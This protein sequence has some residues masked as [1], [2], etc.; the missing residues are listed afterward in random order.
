MTAFSTLRWGWVFLKRTR[1]LCGIQ[2]TKHLIEFVLVETKWFV[3]S[4]VNVIPMRQTCGQRSSMSAWSKRQALVFYFRLRICY[5]LL[6]SKRREESDLGLC[7]PSVLAKRMPPRVGKFLQ[8]LQP[9]L[10][11]IRKSA[12]RSGILFAGT[13]VCTDLH[14]TLLYILMSGTYSKFV[15]KIQ[16]PVLGVCFPQT[17]SSAGRMFAASRYVCITT[18][19]SF[20]FHNNE[21]DE[22]P[23]KLK[24]TVNLRSFEKYPTPPETC[25]K[26][27]RWC[28]S[29]RMLVNANGLGI[30]VTSLMHMRDKTYACAWHNSLCLIGSNAMAA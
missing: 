28:F 19:E 15:W 7:T 30:C 16:M 20:R 29:H 13:E 27:T 18:D 23:C 11:F 4:N 10:F 17:C 9:N 12:S 22:R 5:R 2:F 3:S 6:I 26:H 24:S 21:F 14:P 25:G 8:I 1:I